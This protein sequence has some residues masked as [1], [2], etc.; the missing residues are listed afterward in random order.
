MPLNDADALITA[1]PA[2]GAA[3]AS[4]APVPSD[5]LTMRYYRPDAQFEGYIDPIQASQ[6]WA[7]VAD[8]AALN[9]LQVGGGLHE[10]DEDGTF[11]DPRMYDKIELD[12]D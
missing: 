7:K 9:G 12:G 5:S 2:L 11:L 1:H 3:R 4:K 8:L 10:C 6:F